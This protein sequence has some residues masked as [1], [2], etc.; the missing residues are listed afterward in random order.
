MEQTLSRE[1]DAGP[2]C[3]H[4]HHLDP[5]VYIRCSACLHDVPK[6]SATRCQGALPDLCTSYV[7]DECAIKCDS[8]DLVCCEEHRTGYD[9]AQAFW[10]DSCD[11]IA[12]QER[13]QAAASIL[14]EVAA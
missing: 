3:R 7:C 1:S 11:S 9:V 8:C 12:I 14:A 5:T 6:T 2:I 13:I 4:P 10:C